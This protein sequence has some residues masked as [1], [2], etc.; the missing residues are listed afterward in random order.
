MANHDASIGPEKEQECE[1]WSRTS[2][3]SGMM[4]PRTGAGTCAS[5]SMGESEVSPWEHFL[6]SDALQLPGKL[7]SYTGLRICI[8][9]LSQM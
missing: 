1:K 3:L 7:V 8:A 2:W 4:A 9:P 6:C 5:A